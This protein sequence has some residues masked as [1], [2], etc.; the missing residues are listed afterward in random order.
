MKCVCGKP[1]FK[2]KGFRENKKWL[3]ECGIIIMFINK[4][5]KVIIS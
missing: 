1:I 4:K 5:P 3:C 2:S